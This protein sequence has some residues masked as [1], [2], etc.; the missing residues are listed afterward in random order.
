MELDKLICS[1]DSTVKEVMVCIDS[2]AKKVAFIVN[3]SGELIGVLTDGDIR[4]L[5]INGYGLNDKIKE[6]ISTKFVYANVNE[7]VES[8]KEKFDYRISIIPIVDDRMHLI[9]YVE[10]N[11]NMRISLAQPQLSGNEYKYLMDAFLSTWISSTGKYIT[12]FED[13][14]A[15]YCGV[16][17][18]VAVSNGTTALHLALVA[19][20]IGTGDEVIIPDITFAATINAVLYTGA[21]PVIVDIEEDG[22]CID[23]QEIRKAI[24]KKTKAIIPVH[25]YGQPC[26][27][28]EISL[29]AKEHSLYVIEDCAEA[30]GAEWEQKKVGSFGDIS[31]FS[32]FGNKVI[33]TGEGGMCITDNQEL[34]EKM[35]ILRDHGMSKE[36]RYYHEVVGFNYRMTNLQAAIGVAQ[37]ERLE[38]ILLWR[39]RLE[40]QYRERLSKVDG[41]VLQPKNLV[42]RKKIAWL[43]SILVDENKRDIIINE[44]KKNG[45]DVRAFF[46]PLSEMDIY[47]KY[48]TKCSNSKAISKRGINLPTTIEINGEVIEKIAGI[49]E[50]VN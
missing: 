21:T 10:Y 47:S 8:I 34:S 27:M 25:I 35:R 39:E 26:N 16:K 9:D 5:L 30:H 13:S 14:F 29:I 36:K 43:V 46:I 17:Y 32:F 7:D 50:R 23:P 40:E 37:V 33:T 42:Q 6:H 18:G 11:E 12:K 49:L 38:E 45:I 48:A 24:T 4:R 2:N 31:C 3:G 1:I 44:L 20:G 22:W 41:I 15:K 19:L 28:Q